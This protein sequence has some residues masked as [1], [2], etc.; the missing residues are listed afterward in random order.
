MKQSCD[1]D[2][3]QVWNHSRLVSH[4]TV[5]SCGS[6]E[7][8]EE[9]DN[10]AILDDGATGRRRGINEGDVEEDDNGCFFGCVFG[11]VFCES[12][13]DQDSVPMDGGR[14]PFDLRSSEGGCFGFGGGDGGGDHQHS[15]SVSSAP[16]IRPRNQPQINAATVP[17]YNEAIASLGKELATLSM[18]ERVKYTEQVHGVFDHDRGIHDQ[19]NHDNNEEWHADD[20]AL[21]QLQHQ[22]SIIRS[23]DKEAYS[24][25]CLLA[26]QKYAVLSS[27]E[28]AR[29]FN[30]RYLQAFDYDPK[31][32]ASMIIL[33]FDYKRM[34]FGMDKVAKTITL[35]DLNE[36][37]M[38]QLRNGMNMWLPGRDTAGRPVLVHGM[39]SCHPSKLMNLVSVQCCDFMHCFF[40]FIFCLMPA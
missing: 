24:K 37:D 36:D 29:E 19:D 40:Y 9:E 26:P 6:N 33:N 8:E 17:E 4:A 15:S 16:S 10:I 12:G 23:P 2:M 31:V 1:V 14:Q 11:R 13:A 32:T 21:Q 22:I 20:K 28:E 25:A 27:S 34:F 18:K 7:N 35:G 3:D 39:P 38:I 5:S 30:L